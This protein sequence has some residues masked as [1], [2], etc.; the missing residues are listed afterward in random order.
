MAIRPATWTAK[1]KIDI[2]LLAF[3]LLYIIWIPISA[4]KVLHFS[5][6]ILTEITGNIKNVD[7]DI[8]IYTVAQN[9]YTELGK[10]ESFRKDSFAQRTWLINLKGFQTKSR[11][12]W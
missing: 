3:F 7:I 11:D 10:F 1:K 5:R 2:L 8:Y 9:R 4:S 12:E 6:I